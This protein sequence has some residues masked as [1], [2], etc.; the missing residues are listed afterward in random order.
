MAVLTSGVTYTIFSPYSKMFIGGLSWQTSPGKDNLFCFGVVL[1]HIYLSHALEAVCVYVCH[2]AQ[3]Y[4]DFQSSDIKAS[5]ATKL[6]RSH[7]NQRSVKRAT[8]GDYNG[9]VQA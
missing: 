1:R 2:C 6:K 8:F 7:Y 5:D 9:S 4:C 3:G